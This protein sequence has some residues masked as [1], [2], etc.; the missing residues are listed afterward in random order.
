MFE[1]NLEVQVSTAVHLGHT[2]A[3]TILSQMWA[4][5]L[6]LQYYSAAGNSLECTEHYAG[7]K[8]AHIV[9]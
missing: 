4:G 8:Y 3:F 6:F 5:W 2:I 9:V 1:L 7:K